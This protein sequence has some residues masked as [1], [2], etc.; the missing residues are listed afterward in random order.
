MGGAAAFGE[1]NLGFA[2]RWRSRHPCRGAK[3]AGAGGRSFVAINRGL[4]AAAWAMP[5]R[6]SCRLTDD[7]G[8]PPRAAPKAG[9]LDFQEFFVGGGGSH[10]P[11]REIAVTAPEAAGAAPR[12]GSPALR[13]TA[14]CALS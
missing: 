10:R 12:H 6:P 2:R 14:A 4:S 1:R 13:R 3:R 8:A 11:V 9:W 7:R 5:P